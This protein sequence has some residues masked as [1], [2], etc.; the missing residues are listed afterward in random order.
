MSPILGIWARLG[1]VFGA[2]SV[3]AVAAGGLG[4]MPSRRLGGL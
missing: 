3:G 4:A 1:G 2:S